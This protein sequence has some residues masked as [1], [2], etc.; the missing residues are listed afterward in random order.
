VP[1][2]K[3]VCHS[4][5][6]EAAGGPL[7]RYVDVYRRDGSLIERFDIW[8]LPDPTVNTKQW[9]YNQRARARFQAGWIV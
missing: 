2:P 7:Y 8:A 5:G 1:I 3:L 4:L 6:S 9:G